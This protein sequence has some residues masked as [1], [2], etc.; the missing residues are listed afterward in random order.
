VNI[1]EMLGKETVISS[2]DVKNR[3]TPFIFWQTHL[4]PSNK[5]R[6]ASKHIPGP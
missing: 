5:D 1:P 4:L 3:Q 2:F 6:F